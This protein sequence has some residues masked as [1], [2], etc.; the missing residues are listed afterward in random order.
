MTAPQPV[1]R[2]CFNIDDDI[3][4]HVRGMEPGRVRKLKRNTAIHD[5]K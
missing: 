1:Q 2:C 5:A 3:M 4:I